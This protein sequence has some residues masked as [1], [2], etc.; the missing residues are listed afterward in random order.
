[1]RKKTIFDLLTPSKKL[2]DFRSIFYKSIKDKK[3][4][5]LE[6]QDRNINRY[7][8]VEISPLFNQKVFIGV[9]ILLKDITQHVLDMAKIK[10][11]QDML[12]ESERLASLGQLI[13]RNCS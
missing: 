4:S 6:Y 9:L 12:M 13:G 5:T 11:N 2:D 7:F 3:P 8:N 1:M 10:D